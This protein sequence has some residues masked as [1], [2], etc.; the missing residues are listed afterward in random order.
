MDFYDKLA[1]ALATVQQYLE[2]QQQLAGFQSSLVSRHFYDIS[3]AGSKNQAKRILKAMLFS[4]IHY[5]PT[6]TLKQQCQQGLA[7]K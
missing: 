4:F 2:Y 6:L 7:E 1:E 3:S 5:R